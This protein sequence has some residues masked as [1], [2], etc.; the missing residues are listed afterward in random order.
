MKEHLRLIIPPEEIRAM[1]EAVASRIREDYS[2]RNPVLIG[3]LKG[4]FIFLADLARLVDIPL[5][6]DFI[7]T[8]SYGKNS[9]PSPDI[10][11]EKDMTSDIKGRDVILVEGIVDTGR[12]SA[13]LVDYMKKKGAKTASVCSLLV[14]RGQHRVKVDYMGAEVDEG[15]VVGYGLDYK[16]DAR[17]LPG[18]YVRALIE[19]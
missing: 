10:L 9:K 2:G 18:L 14:R 5:E 17:G 4:S 8:S 3:V 16:E 12:T 7:Q 11:V 19:R 15:F 13:A 6:I 1:V